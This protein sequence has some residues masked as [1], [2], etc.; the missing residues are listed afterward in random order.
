MG[1][2]L[3]GQL[4][5]SRGLVTPDQLRA[6]LELASK[7]GPAKP[8]GAILVSQGLVTQQ[9]LQALLAEQAAIPKPSPLGAGAAKKA[10]KNGVE[11]GAGEIE[12]AFE[13]DGSTFEIETSGESRVIE[14]PAERE[15]AP[16]PAPV[17]AP[18]PASPAPAA[19]Q[20]APARPTQAPVA[21]AAAVASS[22]PNPALTKHLAELV[23]FATRAFASDLH[24][25]PGHPVTIRQHGKLISG[26]G[27][28]LAAATLEPALR[29]MLGPEGRA[30]LEAAGEAEVIFV[31][32]GLR[33][34][35]QVFREA[36]GMSAILRVAPAAPP[37]LGALG[38]PNMLARFVTGQGL[39]LLTGPRGSGKTWTLAA[40]VD[41]LNTERQDHIVCI[42][43]PIE[44]VHPAKRCVVSQR[45]VPTHAASVARAVGAALH[46]DPDVVVIGEVEDEQTAR[47]ALQAAEG[48]RLVLATFAASSA[49]RAVTR[50]LGLFPSDQQAMVGAMLAGSLRAVVSQRLVSAADGQRRAPI[51]ELV[52]VDAA[53]ASL[54][55]EGRAGEITPTV[56]LD[57]ALALAVRAGTITREEAR[58]HADR[59]EAFS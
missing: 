21:T 19:A 28:P 14:T 49:V 31:V 57:Q 32:S 35:A 39:V 10:N 51:C 54:I 25:H 11:H 46:E 4:A 58:V 3:L 37:E 47:L 44:F 53:V 43:R 33:C 22:A 41:L 9:Q 5:V 1:G 29:E 26:N 7:A 34:R 36:A 56:G 42:E 8:L 30:T 24:L 6:C 59:A 15:P 38:L 16:A 48:G 40:L 20:A 12:I 18:P 27:A 55:A 45:E 52:D 23:V 17:H 2:G 50:L 13:D